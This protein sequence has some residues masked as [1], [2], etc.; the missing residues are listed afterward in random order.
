MIV[1][2]G[3]WRILSSTIYHIR[4]YPTLIGEK[5]KD[6]WEHDA[7]KRVAAGAQLPTPWLFEP[8]KP[9]VWAAV[10][11]PF[12]S[13]FTVEWTGVRPMGEQW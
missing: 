13:T 6:S 12:A 1:D 4:Y 8:A 10:S 9:T 11:F 2:G 3:P 5:G 7:M